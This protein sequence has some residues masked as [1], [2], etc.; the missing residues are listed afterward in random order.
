MLTGRK[1]R[2][3]LTVMTPIFGQN[4]RNIQAEHRGAAGVQT[5]CPKVTISSFASIQY[6]S[7]RIFISS[8]S[9]SSGDWVLT[10]PARLE[11][12]CTWVSTQMALRLK[13]RLSTKLA[14]LLPTPGSFKSSDWELGTTELK[15]FHK[16]SDIS[17]IC[18]AFVL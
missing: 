9:V 1:L 3:Y 15:F 14:V 5:S 13:A 16:F 17:T 8:F 12:R 10:H 18:F 2:I 11:K 6:S 4:E 7:G